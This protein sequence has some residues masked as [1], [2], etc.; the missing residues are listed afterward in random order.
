MVRRAAVVSGKNLESHDAAVVEKHSRPRSA[1]E[2]RAFMITTSRPEASL[3]PGP[4]SL[5]LY[6]H[7]VSGKHIIQICFWVLVNDSTVDHR[8]MKTPT[9]PQGGVPG[10]RAQSRAVRWHSDS[11]DPVLVAKQNRLA[12][13]LQNVPHVDGVVVVTS[14]KQATWAKKKRE[15]RKTGN[16]SSRSGFLQPWKHQNFPLY[17]SGQ[18]C[19]TK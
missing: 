11:A 6:V 15:F 18:W 9:H 10:R 17:V 13:P 12:S 4:W 3:S 7:T 19:Q 16:W 2:E 8:R 5:W 14:E 1:R